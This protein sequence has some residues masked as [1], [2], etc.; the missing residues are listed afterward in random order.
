MHDGR[1]LPRLVLRAAAGRPVTYDGLWRAAC[2]AEVCCE[3]NVPASRAQS[4][5]A[6]LRAIVLADESVQRAIRAA[7][8]N[9]SGTAPGA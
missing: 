5:L 1:H 6:H 8:Q 2:W 9:T 4:A 7:A 3:P